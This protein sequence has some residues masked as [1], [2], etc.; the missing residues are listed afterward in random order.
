VIL[1]IALQ[2]L[3]VKTSG[4]FGK[5]AMSNDVLLGIQVKEKDVLL[6]QTC[7]RMHDA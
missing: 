6:Y 7:E 1:I 4:F 2:L 3:E 5:S